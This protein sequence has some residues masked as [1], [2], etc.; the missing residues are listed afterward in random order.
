MRAQVCVCD[1]DAEV[2]LTTPPKISSC[3]PHF[4]IPYP[5]LAPGAC[6]AH[7]AGTFM[8]AQTH[9]L[10]RRSTCLHVMYLLLLQSL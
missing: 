8:H 5:P 3:R 1:Y 2:Q 6:E 10:V 9:T 4:A 7:T